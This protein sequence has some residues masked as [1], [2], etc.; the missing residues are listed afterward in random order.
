MSGATAASTQHGGAS[1]INSGS[2]ESD[3][4]QPLI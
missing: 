3:N 4:I 2:L 1:A